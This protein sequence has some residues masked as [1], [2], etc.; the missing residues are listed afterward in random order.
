MAF[1]KAEGAL[2]VFQCPGGRIGAVT[3]F[4]RPGT[5]D[6]KWSF[7]ATMGSLP[8]LSVTPEHYNRMYR[9]LKRG[10]P[11][12]VEVEVRNRVEVVAPI[13]PHNAAWREHE[14]LASIEAS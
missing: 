2:V 13:R 6:D 5:R 8:I 11:V 4:A 7:E 3:G 1:Y 9:I 12:K 10:L 14:S